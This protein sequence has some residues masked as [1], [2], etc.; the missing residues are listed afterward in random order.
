[1]AV[2]FNG[3]LTS[4]L[5]QLKRLERGG[6]LV[7]FKKGK[8]RVYGFNPRYPFLQALEQ[9]LKRVMFFMSDADKN[10]YYYARSR[11]RRS[12]KPL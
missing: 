6:V 7:S 2:N 5:K 10:K 3:Q 9:L 12:G 11:P 4:F 8:T 1:M